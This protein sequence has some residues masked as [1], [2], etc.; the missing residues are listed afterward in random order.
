[1]LTYE[2]QEQNRQDR[3]SEVGTLP[4]C[5]MCGVLR[6]QRTDYIRCNPCG[7]NWLNGEDLDKNPKI[8]R[9]KQMLEEQR[10]SSK[11][12]GK[13]DTASSSARE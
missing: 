3:L 13:Q 11:D 7:V 2:Q 1:M 4:P 6:V 10:R 12:A 5:P 9:Y 8:A